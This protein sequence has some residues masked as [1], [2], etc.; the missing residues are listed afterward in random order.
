MR[1]ISL[2][3][4]LFLN[5]LL[6]GTSLSQWQWQNPL[7]QGNTLND[8]FFIDQTTGWAVGDAGTIMKSNDGGQTYDLF[9]YPTHLN[10]SGVEFFDL[11]TGLVTGD[12]GIILKTTDGGLTWNQIDRGFY[13]NITDI[14]INNDISWLTCDDGTVFKS[15]DYGESW[16]L[17]YSDPLIQFTSVSFVDASHGWAAGAF[18]SYSPAMIRTGDGGATWSTVDLPSENLVFDIC[19]IDTLTGY[20]SSMEMYDNYAVTAIKKVQASSLPPLPE[21]YREAHLDLGLRFRPSEVGL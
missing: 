18:E 6:P 9:N 8:L 16:Q 3:L 7:P 15:I 21:V 19:F 2:I 1:T 10:F 4:V 14:N 12:S 5:L 20:V 11:N 13:G 17:V